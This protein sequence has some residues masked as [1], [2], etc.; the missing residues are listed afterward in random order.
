MSSKT[1]T[2]PGSICRF[3]RRPYKFP[4][5]QEI[6]NVRC[7][8]AGCLRCF[9]G[10]GIDV[11]DTPRPAYPILTCPDATCLRSA[12]FDVRGIVFPDHGPSTPIVAKSDH[13]ASQLD[14]DSSSSSED[15]DAED[16]DDA[17]AEGVASP[18][19]SNVVGSAIAAEASFSSQ[20]RPTCHA[21][22]TYTPTDT[23]A[24]ATVAAA[25]VSED[26]SDASTSS[27]RPTVTASGTR[28]S[29]R[30]RLSVNRY[31]P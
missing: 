1:K 31:Q 14:D 6:V 10:S 19:G 23:V 26:V 25:F 9:L 15:G 5:R 3:C 2:P 7:R 30:L 29:A 27:T 4:Y 11:T 13:S 24:P 28:R 20:D 17:F 21:L 8:H 12:T 22:A 18:S 16:D